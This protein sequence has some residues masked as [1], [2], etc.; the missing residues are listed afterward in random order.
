MGARHK[1]GSDQASQ[2]P[3]PLAPSLLSHSLARAS[4]MTALSQT[5]RRVEVASL[6][7]ASPSS[8][9][10]ILNLDTSRNLASLPSKVTLASLELSLVNLELSLASLELTLVYL[11]PTLPLVNLATQPLGQATLDIHLSRDSCEP[12]PSHQVEL[13]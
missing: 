11:V 3:Q 10:A 2:L 6:V 8:S 7:K 1:S 9:L 12:F 4:V 13:S 5:S